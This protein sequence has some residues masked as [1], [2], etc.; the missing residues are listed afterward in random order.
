MQLRQRLL[1]QRAVKAIVVGVQTPYQSSNEQRANLYFCDNS[2]VVAESG[3]E[4][5]QS[6]GVFGPGCDAVHFRLQFG[7]SHRLRPEDR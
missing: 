7:T 4:V 6:L 1:P 3:P 5:A 2:R